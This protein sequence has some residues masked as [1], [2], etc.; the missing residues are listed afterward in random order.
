MRGVVPRAPT[1]GD[2]ACG[3]IFVAKKPRPVT[4]IIFQ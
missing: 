3:N 1:I 2:T 4:P